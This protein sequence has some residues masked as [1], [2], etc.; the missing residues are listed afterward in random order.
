M[1]TEIEKQL[2]TAEQGVK[3]WR[4]ETNIGVYSL[5][6]W[7]HLLSCFAASD[8]ED[9]S[10][11]LPY[12]A[13]DLSEYGLDLSS[14]SQILDIGCLG[15]YGLFDFYLRREISGQPIPEMTGIDL[16]D[17][18]IAL[19]RFMSEHGVWDKEKSPRFAV[20]SAESLPFE[21]EAFDFVIARLL[22]PYVGI[23]QAMKEIC[24]VMK[25]GGIA[26]LQL[27]AP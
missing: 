22:L 4:A 8:C 1:N 5:N 17:E 6:M 25:P 27:H 26:L 10:G 12:V 11:A 24:R 2:A 21:E 9:K 3:D 13:F 18:S 15:G 20:A 16:S 7:R 14:D 23:E 19:A